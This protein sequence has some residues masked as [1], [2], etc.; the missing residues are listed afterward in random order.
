MRA[1]WA[2]ASV[3][4]LAVAACLSASVAAQWVK[5][6]TPGVPRLADGSPNLAAPPPRTADGRPDFSG[7]WMIKR[8]RMMLPGGQAPV[9]ISPQM[10][11]IGDGLEGGLPYQAWARALA[12][13]RRAAQSADLPS[14]HCLPLGPMLAHTYLDP[15]K[16]LQM[17]GLIVIL[18]ERDFSYR[19]IFTDGRALPRDPNPSWYGYSTATFDGDALIVRTNGLRDGL[20]LDFD[21]NVIT[22]AATLTEK[23]RRPTFGALDI[24]VTVD[25]PH[26][27]TRPWTVT[28]H[29]T[30]LA[31]TELLE[32]VCLESE[33]DGSHL[34]GK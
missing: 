21:G 34:A 33:K 17:P 30:L 13:Q 25:D 3:A 15:R 23:F 31:D 19:Q 14:T 32:F 22:S 1:R 29:Q 5:Y 4:V 20:W 8:Q 10:V 27:Y 26:A 6:P 2:G 28:L 11:N 16:I 18:N 9:N 7:M 24:D 12:D